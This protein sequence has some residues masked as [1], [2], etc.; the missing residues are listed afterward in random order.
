MINDVL[1]HAKAESGY[2]D[3]DESTVEVDSVI[4]FAHRMLAPRAE[5]AGVALIT[6]GIRHVMVRGDER[7]LRQIVL[8][9]VTNGIK[10]TPSGGRIAIT[11]SFGTAGDLVLTVEDTGIGIAEEEQSR[12]FEPFMQSRTSSSLN[13]E[14]T[15]L[16]L[17][18]TKRLI[19]LHQ[20][21]VELRSTLGVGTTVIV[22]LPGERVALMPVLQPVFKF[23]D[24][25]VLVV[26]DDDLVRTAAVD[27]LEGIG[28]TVLS[29]A[30]ANE[31]LVHLQ[32]G[33]RIDL[34]FTDV[35]MPPGMNGVELAATV[36]AMRPN[37]KVLL[38]S[39]FCRRRPRPHRRQPY[40]AS[41][42]GKPYTL[43]G[44]EAVVRP[45]V[46]LWRTSPCSIGAPG[47]PN[48]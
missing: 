44:L 18:L 34:L 3:L 36:A 19:E 15:G 10:F 9:L 27:M 17:P 28:L 30:N 11:T 43:A 35:V 38:T 6:S 13:Q 16:G 40:R 26:D 29:A 2:L 20:G 1:D 5:R 47:L 37:V 42:I 8:N 48:G 22:R 4:D 33:A 39:G 25:A 23:R 7:R 45:P 24:A 21:S 12:I 32:Q 31:A 14:G 41:F 46:R